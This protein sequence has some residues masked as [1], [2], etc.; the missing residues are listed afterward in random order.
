M[1]AC[2]FVDFFQL[3]NISYYLQV[4]YHYFSLLLLLLLLLLLFVIIIIIIIIYYI[5]DV[6]NFFPNFIIF[7]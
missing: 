6:T 4:H 1:K 3:L 7:F 5:G 2:F